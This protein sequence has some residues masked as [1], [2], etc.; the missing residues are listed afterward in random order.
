MS[1]WFEE[2]MKSVKI[3]QS[4]HDAVT[5]ILVALFAML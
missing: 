5:Q 4:K 3:V 2:L 1:E